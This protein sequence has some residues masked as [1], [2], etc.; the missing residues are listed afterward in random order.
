MIW[1]ALGAVSTATIILPP[2]IKLSLYPYV[3]RWP[4]SV[5]I[6]GCLVLLAAAIFEA[7]FKLQ[8]KQA[9][10]RPRRSPTFSSA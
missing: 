2:E 7:G 1:L 5:W 6:I 10:V 8:K 9:R 3:P 4:L